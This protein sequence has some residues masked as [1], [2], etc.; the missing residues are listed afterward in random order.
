MNFNYNLESY[1][2]KKDLTEELNFYKSI[3]LKKV[4]SGDYNSALV[5]IRS[6]LVLLEE[7]KKDFKLEKEFID[8]YE[9]REEVQKE[10]SSHRMIYER[11]FNNLLR[12]K[13]N[14]SNL[15]NFSRLLAMLKS[16]VDQNL[17]RYNLE[18]ISIKI[19]KYFK[20]IKRLYEILSCY[21]VLN[22][23]DA[24][25]KIFDF[26]KDIKT[27]NF[28][29]L[30]L[31]IS[32]VYQNLLNYRLSEFSKEYDRI[33]L[34]LLSNRL[35]I[36]QEKLVDFITLIMKQPKSPIKSFILDTGEI[37]FRKSGF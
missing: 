32:L 18:D 10:L 22:Y 36:N 28:P 15:E 20:F 12:E 24:S 29:N 30:K 4:K 5:K 23:H 9:L 2:N 31:L 35:E 25:G 13:L 34:S 26:V 17:E 11:R 37:S 33:S 1:K 19:T 8:F 3:I 16:E 6:A 21:K 27:E 14:E 7:Y